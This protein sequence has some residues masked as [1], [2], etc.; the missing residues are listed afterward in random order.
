M[1][2]ACLYT[3]SHVKQACLY[4]DS[5]VKQA[6]LYTDSHMKQVSL[7]TNSFRFLGHYAVV[8][9][10]GVHSSLMPWAS[11]VMPTSLVFLWCRLG[12]TLICV[13]MSC[14]SRFRPS[15]EE[16]K[17]FQGKR[18]MG[19]KL[20]RKHR[21]SRMRVHDAQNCDVTSWW[22][23]GR[24]TWLQCFINCKEHK[25][26]QCQSGISVVMLNILQCQFGLSVQQL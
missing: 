21:W 4:T 8:L 17:Q 20:K 9:A 13:L 18:K 14:T 1:K 3:D 5:H 23:Q 2:Q 25:R 19:M 22:R 7:Y 11:L 12:M 16:R 15:Y 10:C 26:L 24:W 6:C